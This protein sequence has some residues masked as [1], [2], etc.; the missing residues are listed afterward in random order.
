MLRGVIFDIDGTLVASNDAHA[1]S[2]ADALSEA[3]FDVPFDVIWSMIGMGGDKLLPSATGVESESSFGKKLSRRRWDIFE[4]DYLPRLAPTP[5]ARELVEKLGNDGFR[6]IVASFRDV[7]DRIVCAETPQ[8]FNAV[9]LWY[10]DFSQT[11]DDEVHELL[12]RA[13]MVSSPI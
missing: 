11:T 13:R 5:G 6:L 3:G 9:G 10:E 4:R 2:W 8:P 7:A 12:D 1:R